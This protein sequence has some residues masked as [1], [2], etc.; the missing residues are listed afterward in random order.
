MP[1]GVLGT[2][3]VCLG[4]APRG[5][6]GLRGKGVFEGGIS[7]AF[8]R[9]GPA[10]LSAAVFRGVPGAGCVVDDS[11]RRV[12]CD[13]DVYMMAAALVAFT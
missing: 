3:E 4:G 2:V 12:R 9:R 8:G 1:N 7:E 5:L 13:G 11:L 6:H 10:C